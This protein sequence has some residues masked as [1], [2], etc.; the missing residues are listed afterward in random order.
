MN[1]LGYTRDFA[2]QCAAWTINNQGPARKQCSLGVIHNIAGWI[3]LCPRHYELIF[4]EFEDR[5]DNLNAIRVKNLQQRLDKVTEFEQRMLREDRETYEFSEEDFEARRRSQTVYFM[6]C[7]QFV[8]IG[9]SHNPHNRLRQLRKGGGTSFPS[10][11]DI[12]AVELIATEPGG[13]EREK[14]LHATFAHLRH[15]GE[16]F[17]EAPE[18]TEYINELE[19]KA[20]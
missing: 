1:G 16:W 2:H 20:A 7:E 17:T 8:K 10:R 14:E 19:R 15:T 11:L 13:F 3:Y 4:Q 5:I 12:A 9:V 6:R 18:L